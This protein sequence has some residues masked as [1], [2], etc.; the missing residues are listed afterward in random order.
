MPT[1][2]TPRARRAARPK[3]SPGI[4]EGVNAQFKRAA[5]LIDC[6]PG[7]LDHIRICNN[8]YSIDF[9]VRVG[10]HVRMFKGYRAE[11]SQHRKPLK[12]G[13]RFSLDVNA[14]EVAGLAALMTYKCA[15]VNVP[16]GGS[17]G[18]VC[19]DPRTTPVEVLEA[20]TRRYT[21]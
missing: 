18:G 15:I 14:D 11:H 12:G 16:F 17:K 2:R 19:I 10:K 7:I 21:F 1:K 3:K 5:A 4:L 9:P 8:I 6:E 13:I 20:V